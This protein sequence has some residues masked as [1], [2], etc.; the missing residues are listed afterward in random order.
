[1]GRVTIAQREHGLPARIRT[2]G[3]T[4]GQRGD[5]RAAVGGPGHGRPA[6]ARPP[7][8]PRAGTRRA[9][10][11]T[12]TLR[13]KSLG[14]NGQR[15]H[16]RSAGGV[17]RHRRPARTASHDPAGLRRH[18]LGDTGGQRG[19]GLRG[20]CRTA[21]TRP[22][23]YGRPARATGCGRSGRL[24]P[25]HADRRSFDRQGG[26]RRYQLS[27]RR[28]HR[29]PG[30]WSR[31][32]RAYGRGGDTVAA[33]ARAPPATWA[34]AAG[35]GGPRCSARGGSHPV[36]AIASGGRTRPCGLRR[37]GAGGWWLAAGR[38]R[39]QRPRRPS[40]AAPRLVDQS[41]FPAAAGP[42]GCRCWAGGR[43]G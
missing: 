28:G 3:G 25:H 27:D 14:T 17:L 13:A 24:R 42:P 6:R 37:L 30:G 2:A 31:H 22:R 23:R 9:S 19:Q 33:K 29:G 11:D 32:L 20:H 8:G 26:W 38:G 16:G 5:G 10:E 34:F 39:T 43:G 35:G 40:I 41:A 7:S 36:A 21:S 12:A 4:D 15:G 18:G 1:M